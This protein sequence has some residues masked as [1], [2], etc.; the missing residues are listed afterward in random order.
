MKGFGPILIAAVVMVVIL[1]VEGIYFNVFVGTTVTKE[2][3]AKELEVIKAVNTVE[4]VKRGL[5]YA[6]YYSFSETLRANS[7]SSVQDITDT[8]EFVSSMNTIFNNYRKASEDNIGV[9]IP[10]GRI[11]LSISDNE[12][13]LEFSSDGLLSYE[14]SSIKISDIADTTIKISGNSLI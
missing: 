2:E 8:D 10:S 7:Y 5:P 9:K 4:A 12:A 3:A 6:L 14:S 1:V 11:K 13:T